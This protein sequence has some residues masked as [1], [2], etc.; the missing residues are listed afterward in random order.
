MKNKGQI[1]LINKGTKN[2]NQI[3]QEKYILVMNK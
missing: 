1:G 3:I 2:K